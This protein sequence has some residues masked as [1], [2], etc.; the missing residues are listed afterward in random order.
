MKLYIIIV[1]TRMTPVLRR[2][3]MRDILMFH[4]LWG[5]KS[6]DKV[7][8]PQLLKRAEADSNLR[9]SAYQPNALPLGLFVA[10]TLLVKRV[11]SVMHGPVP[12]SCSLSALCGISLAFVERLIRS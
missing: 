11:N 2:A 7:H 3:A 10:H 1:T 8:R 9:L 6:Q 5:T 12:A 4:S